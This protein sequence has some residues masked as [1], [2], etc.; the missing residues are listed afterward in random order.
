MYMIYDK[1]VLSSYNPI[2]LVFPKC[3]AGQ[4][5]DILRYRAELA[6]HE[7]VLDKD[8]IPLCAALA[9][10][11]EDDAGYALDLLPYA[12]EETRKEGSSR[13]MIQH[14]YLVRNLWKRSSEEA[15]KVK[16]NPRE[17]YNKCNKLLIKLGYDSLSARRLASL[18]AD[19]E[20]YGFVIKVIK[21]RGKS[22][23]VKWSVRISDTVDRTL[24]LETLERKLFAE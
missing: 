1:R 13:V 4:L 3:N 5:C 17:V 7:G 8:V 14:V 21:S 11:R 2:K 23:G 16:D 10:E 19:L 9:M 6:F 12:G 20:L 24:V 18:L 22:R 15:L